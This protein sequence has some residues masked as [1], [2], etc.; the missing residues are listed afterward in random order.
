M[1]DAP[2]TQPKC[3]ACGQPMSSVTHGPTTFDQCAGCGGL[4]FDLMEHR[5]LRDEDPKAAE[6]DVR[7]APAVGEAEQLAAPKRTCPR[8]HVAMTRLKDVDRR[9][10][11][12]DYCSICNGTFFDAGEFKRYVTKTEGGLLKRLGL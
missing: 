4:W 8:C 2:A 3:P 6:I 11:I 12:Y 9:D 7:P 1:S 10:V 5:H